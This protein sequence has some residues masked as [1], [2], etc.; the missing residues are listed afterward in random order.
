MTSFIGRLVL[1]M[2]GWRVVGA[3]PPIS[4]FVF[5][6]APHTSN[7]D[8]V[9]MLAA[10]WALQVRIPWFAKHTVF[11]GP[12][13]WI[14]RALG[15]LSVDRRARHDLV[16]HV[17]QLFGQSDILRLG[18]APEGTRSRRDYWKSGFY[19]IA[20]RADVPVVAAF[21][22]YATRRCGVGPI[23]QLTGDVPADMDR[24]RAFY[25]TL[26]G[27][28]PELQGPIRLRDERNAMDGWSA[29]WCGSSTLL[30]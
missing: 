29:M 21:L 11:W 27:R 2:F 20:R 12:L 6:G 16:E 23:I 15:G 4:R 7:W 25:G 18:I 8:L 22:D 19:Y 30:R 3:V 5:I 14:F 28:Y 26:Q 9:V 17:A 1:R 13:G 24:I 10:G